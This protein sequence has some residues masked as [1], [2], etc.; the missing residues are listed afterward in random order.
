MSGWKVLVA[1]VFV[2][3]LSAAAQAAT[4]AD[5]E[6]GT[7]PGWGMLTNSGIQPWAGQLSGGVITANASALNGSKVLQLSGQPAFNFQS[8][9]PGGAAL[10]FDFL[11]QNLRNDFLGHTKLEFDWVG[12]PDGVSTSGFSQLYNIILNSQ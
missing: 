7:A 11:S 4:F 6:G 3:S 8:P 12:A 10:G 9:D 5:F 1:V 2:A